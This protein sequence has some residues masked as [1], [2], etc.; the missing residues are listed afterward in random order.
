MRGNF[1]L[2][3]AP[4]PQ[5]AAKISLR[6]LGLNPHPVLEKYMPE[7]LCLAFINQRGKF[8]R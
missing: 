7:R 6:I 1:I 2:N 5:F 3:E 8:V 4:R